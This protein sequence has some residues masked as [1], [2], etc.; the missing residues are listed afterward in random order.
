ML[1]LMRCGVHDRGGWLHGGSVAAKLIAEGHSI[2]GLVRTSEKARLI[3]QLGIEPVIGALDDSNLLMTEAR[4]ADGVIDTASADHRPSV[5]A[6]SPHL[7]VQTNTVFTYERL[8]R[9]RR[10]R[11]RRARVRNYLR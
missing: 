4:P 9:D 11:A 3:E 8:Q 5:E 2:P 1:D 7:S 6:L 10:R